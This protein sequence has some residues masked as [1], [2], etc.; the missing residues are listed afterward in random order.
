MDYTILKIQSD[1]F[2]HIRLLRGYK[3]EDDEFS[4]RCIKI[5]DG[6]DDCYVVLA[7]DICI[8]DVTVTYKSAD[9]SAAVENHRAYL[10]GLFVKEEY[11][12]RKIALF[13]IKHVIKELHEKGYKE[14]SVLVDDSNMPA[15]S[16][17]AKLGFELEKSFKIDEWTFTL[18]VYR[19]EKANNTHILCNSY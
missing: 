14:L 13:L 10:S 8:A 4:D 12:N 1:L 2:E 17:Y 3:K 11:R 6:S 9:K 19:M 16:L 5:Q 18:L 15:C 7:N